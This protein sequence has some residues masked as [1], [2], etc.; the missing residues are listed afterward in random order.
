MKIDLIK[1]RPFLPAEA[2]GRIRTTLAVMIILL[3]APIIGTAQVQYN[4]TRTVV[5]LPNTTQT[6]RPGEATVTP[7]TRAFCSDDNYFFI[8]SSTKGRKVSHDYSAYLQFSLAAIPEGAIIDTVDLM[9]YVNKVKNTSSVFEQ[10]VNLYEL[11]HARNNQVIDI[12]DSSAIAM[13]LV[14]QNDIAQAIHLQPDIADGGSWVSKRNGNFY[15]ILAAEEAETYRYYTERSGDMPRQP[16]LVISYHMPAN[17]VRKN[18]WPQ[19]KYDAQHT[20]TLGWQ[21]NTTATG[22]KL[23]NTFSPAGANYIKSDPLLNDDR[24]VM[25]YQASAPPMYRLLS[26]SQQGNFLAEAATDAIGL[27]KYGPI[28]DRTGNIYCMS[29]NTGGTLTV[30]SPDRLQVIFTKQL[31]NSA[32]A[33][34]TPVI[35]FDRSIYISTDKGIY[36][37]TPQPECKLKW[38]YAVATNRFGTAALNEAEQ[39]VYVYDGANGNVTAL[40]SIDGSKKWEKN[41]G[42]TFTTDIPVPSVKNARLCVTNGLRRG[43]SFYIMDA[44]DGRVLRT[45][46]AAT[47]VIS[48]PVIG[49]DKVFVINNGRLESY[50]LSNPASQSAATVTGLNP[51]GALALDASDNVYIL[52]TEQGKQSLTMVAPGA[53]TFPSLPID[54]ANGYLSGNRLILTPSGRLLAG[55]DNHLYTI[56]P[57]GF[58]AKDDITI[59]FGNASEFTSEYLYRSEGVVRVAGKT[60]TGTQNIVIHGGK[61]IT[62]QPNFS[63]QKGATFNCKTGF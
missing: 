46:T 48:Q 26:L 32:Q 9:V 23:N 2:P 58:N 45:V 44:N 27:V 42:S 15:C 16:K 30:L 35:G 21:T 24:L 11:T 18:S 53:T 51:A 47:D 52:N 10:G 6:Q 19:Y 54:D 63:V 28:A 57:T 36:A 7:D 1:C 59:P 17:Q 41:V 39:T 3:L 8:S 22:F 61:G 40:N 29:G 25:A 56:S 4:D 37:Y 43:S 13:T 33:T 31:E 12:A 34:A 62:F 38:V 20:A 14:S 55:N 49:S 50:A 60:L 5:I